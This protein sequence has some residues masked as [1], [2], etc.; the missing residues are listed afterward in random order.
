[1][2]ASK[3]LSHLV[4][5]ALMIAVPSFAQQASETKQ[6]SADTATTVEKVSDKPAVTEGTAQS[7][8]DIDQILTNK[9][10]RAEA[11]SKSKYSFSALLDYS[12]GSIDKPLDEERPNITLARGLPLKSNLSASVSGRYRLTATDSLSAGL[13]LRWVAPLETGSLRPDARSGKVQ[14]RFDAS[15]PFLG[16]DK[17]YGWWGIQ[18][19]LSVSGTAYTNSDLRDIGFV[20]GF[21]VSQN[22]IYNFGDTGFAVGLLL[23]AGTGIYD[24]KGQIEGE[25]PGVTY[26]NNQTEY[27]IGAY[28]FLEY[29]INDTFNLRTISGIWVYEH[30]R[31][32]SDPHTYFKNTIYQSV[33]LGIS[34]TRDI[35][36]YPN[37]QF[38][39]EDLRDDRTNVAISASLNVF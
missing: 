9:K 6:P 15:N 38:V 13:G 1:M 18:S 37:I 24:K 29:V 33:G 32:A 28:P 25:D 31:S 8:E 35:F 26:E 27:S 20:A 11:G 2:F 5:T 36:L 16:Y 12:G 23:S 4:I 34:I 17:V 14:D 3:K 21:G 22:N 30:L 10:M 39:P 19:V 7:A